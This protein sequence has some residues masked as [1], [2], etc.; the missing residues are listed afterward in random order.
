MPNVRLCLP[1]AS[2]L[3]ST[4]GDIV[5]TCNKS[6]QNSSMR[7]ERFMQEQQVHRF[8]TMMGKNWVML[9][10]YIFYLTLSAPFLLKLA[11]FGLYFITFISNKSWDLKYI[12][13]SWENQNRSLTYPLVGLFRVCVR[14]YATLPKPGRTWLWNSIIY[15]SRDRR[16]HLQYR[17]Y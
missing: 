14:T 11:G 8:C 1:H 16:Y 5:V 7:L 17:I 15:R 12:F 6:L 4:S 9:L 10:E 13:I 3:P 2:F